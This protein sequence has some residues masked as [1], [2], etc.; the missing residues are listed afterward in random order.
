MK[1]LVKES[2][3]ETNSSSPID[4]KKLK[5]YA[6]A[7][8]VLCNGE[9]GDVFYNESENHVYIC[10]GDSNPFEEGMLKEYMTDAIRKGDY[11]NNKLIK[12]TIENECHPTGDDWKKIN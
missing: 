12:I 1:K 8:A 4:E 6:N 9:Y 10:L 5:E 7:I 2:L 11:S 3:N